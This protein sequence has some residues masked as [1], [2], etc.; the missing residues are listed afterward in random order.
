MKEKKDGISFTVLGLIIGIL[1]IVIPIV[2]Q[3]TRGNT[4]ITLSKL[5]SINL[6]AT[7]SS[8]SEL[9]ILYNGKKIN[10]L[11]KIKF[12]LKNNGNKAITGNDVLIPPTIELKSGNIINATIET[13][14]PSN[15]GSKISIDD[16]NCKI[17]FSL[18]NPKDYIVFSV[19]IDNDKIDYTASCRIKDVQSLSIV[20]T[21]EV[22]KQK[23]KIDWIFFIISGMSVIMF[24]VGIKLLVENEKRKAYIKM[25][26][27]EDKSETNLQT[28]EAF[29]SMVLGIQNIFS[30][31]QK[32]NIN[33]LLDD[34]TNLN[35]NQ[36]R[37][38]LV[39]ELKKEPSLGGSF[40]AIIFALIGIGYCLQYFI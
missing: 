11:L 31:N 1:S 28:R 20:D 36:A 5:S 26:S 14:S 2:W 27:A 22:T 32:K 9:T 29:R 37:I 21:Q 34:L 6:L 19:L 23:K 7:D 35:M 25:L 10:N 12:L 24:A 3:T 15:L 18:L 17:I 38:R 39:Q 8:V 13:E 33:I 16:K 4:N 30:G 40:I